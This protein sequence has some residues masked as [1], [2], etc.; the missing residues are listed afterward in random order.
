LPAKTFQSIHIIS[1]GNAGSLLL[2]SS[3]V[4]GGNLSSYGSQLAAMGHALTDTG[5]ILLYGCNV[6]ADQTG[7]QFVNRFA[8]LT[9]AE[10]AASD[11]ITGGQGDWQLEA[12]TGMVEPALAFGD[13]GDSL[14]IPVVNAT[15]GIT[16]VEGKTAGT[17]TI[18]LDS[19]APAGGLTVNYSLA[20]T[21]A[22]GADYTV[23]AGSNVTVVMGSSFTVAE[24]QSLATLVVN[25]VGD[26]VVD[27]GETV[28]LNLGVGS[29]YQLV[30]GS[31]ASFAPKVAIAMQTVI[32]ILP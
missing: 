31:V 23:S 24:G 16:P 5:D 6:A 7:L 22:L 9:N 8:D 1:H 18:S 26:G 2:G 12:A 21:A 4:T 27:G 17:F 19:P 29:G 14:A 15:A 10:V 32:T 13:Y 11:D 20:G 25:A 28:E 30:N 3:M